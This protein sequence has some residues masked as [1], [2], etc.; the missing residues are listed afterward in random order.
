M[1]S[2]TVSCFNLF[3]YGLTQRLFQGG[4]MNSECVKRWKN[5]TYIYLVKWSQFEKP[6]KMSSQ[7]LSKG[8]NK[9]EFQNSLLFKIDCKLT[10]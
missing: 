8:K 5:K 9:Q 1:S 6:L 10:N 3:S 4:Q 7:I 2:K